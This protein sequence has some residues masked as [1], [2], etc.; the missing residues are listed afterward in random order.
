M[1]T[2]DLT[3]SKFTSAEDNTTWYIDDFGPFK[4]GEEAKLWLQLQAER[5][6]NSQPLEERE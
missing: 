2:D 6:K 4:S 3:F 5:I 1:S